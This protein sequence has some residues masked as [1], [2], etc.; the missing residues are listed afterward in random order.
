MS[1]TYRR[2]KVAM[3]SEHASPLAHLGGVDA[4]GQN[5]AV[6][7]LSAAL[8]AAGHEVVVYTRRDDVDLLERVDTEHGYAVVHV[9]AGPPEPLPKDEL[10][11]YMDSFSVFLAEQWRHWRPDVAHA[12][13]WMS[14]LATLAAAR[15]HA[16]PTVQ[17]FHALGVV[18]RRHQGR[19]DTSP[20]ERVRLE[21]RVA[22]GADWVAA[23]CTDEV[24]ELARMGRC[25]SVSV[26]PCG[27]DPEEFSDRGPVATRGTPQRIV[28]V[29]RLVPRKGFDTVI[30]AMPYLTF[31]AATSDTRDSPALTVCAH[32][33]VRGAQVCG[34]DPQLPAIDARVL[35]DAGVTAVDDPYRAAKSADA[36]VVLTEWPQ[37]ADLDWS[38]I[39]EQAPGAIVADTRNLLDAH[40]VAAAGLRYLGNGR[41]GGY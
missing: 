38:L 26:V 33:A 27:V 25:G 18:K 29:G 9:P 23:T 19:D 8:A 12:H 28:S 16:I 30:A 15:R 14:G 10:L 36:I 17:T 13:F 5:V 2:L 35:H 37:F 40:S 41:V 4:G 22:R 21:T 20:D 7:E 3:V 6:A 31:K 11:Q 39:A 1:S 24:S 34:Y 32:L